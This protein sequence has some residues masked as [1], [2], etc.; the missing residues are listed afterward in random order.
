MGVAPGQIHAVAHASAVR[1]RSA[2]SGVVASAVT[3]TQGGGHG[4]AGGGGRQRGA[5]VLGAGGDGATQDGSVARRAG[6]LPLREGGRGREGARVREGGGGT[7]G[8][9]DVDEEVWGA[10]WAQRGAVSSSWSA[11]TKPK[12]ERSE[13]K[14][15]RLQTSK[16]GHVAFTD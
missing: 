16:Q 9:A 8:V 13:A 5:G 14:L 7:Q 12:L 11:E 2:R 15:R 10:Q 4:G 1:A 6:D 3:V